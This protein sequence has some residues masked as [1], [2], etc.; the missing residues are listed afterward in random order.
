MILADSSVWIDHLRKPEARLVA[1][2]E[3]ANVYVHPF[4]IGELAC[5]R[6]RDRSAFLA[7]LGKLPRIPVVTDP[8]ALVFLEVRQ[9]MGRGIGWVDVHLLASGFN[10]TR[11]IGR[12]PPV[13]SVAVNAGP[14]QILL[15]GADLGVE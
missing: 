1:G 8:E 9:L 7:L 15:D 4:V 2:L 14:A 12:E 3:W 10:Q 11:Q 5:G 13:V 6:F